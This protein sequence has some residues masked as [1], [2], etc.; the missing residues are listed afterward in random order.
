MENGGE[1]DLAG[2]NKK[3]HNPSDY[4]PHPWAQPD[5]S[6]RGV[7]ESKERRGESPRNGHRAWATILLILATVGCPCHWLSFV[8]VETDSEGDFARRGRK[9]HP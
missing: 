9:L 2:E 4:I 7:V 8:G 5:R 3:T 6:E 1:R